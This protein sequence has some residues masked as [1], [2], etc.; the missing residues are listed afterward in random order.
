MV[1]VDVE[2]KCVRTIFVGT[3]TTV[4][5]ENDFWVFHSIVHLF[6]YIGIDSSSNHGAHYALTT[7]IENETMLREKT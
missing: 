2:M 3:K 5:S 4:A 7:T 1:M 6:N